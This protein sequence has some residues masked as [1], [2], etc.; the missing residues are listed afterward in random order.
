MSPETPSARALSRRLIAREDVEADGPEGTPSS[1]WAACERA[2][3][4][5]A[6]WL[7]ANGCRALVAR[8][9]K[10]ARDDHPALDP[11]FLRTEPGP[12]L[13]GVAESIGTHGAAAVEAGLE[14]LLVALV[15]LLGRL[16]G[17]DV[18]ARLLDPGPERSLPTHERDG[19]RAR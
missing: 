6:R 8:A 16:V 10:Q 14:A 18:A 5:L 13:G 1:A 19:E 7:G 17:D 11:L 9:L 12:A 3:G 15:E 4:T 2:C